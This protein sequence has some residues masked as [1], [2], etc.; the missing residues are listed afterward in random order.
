[1]R[2]L[3]LNLAK[4]ASRFGSASKDTANNVM[5]SIGSIFEINNYLFNVEI[6]EIWNKLLKN[7]WQKE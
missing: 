7:K 1:M 3:K 2:Y 6:D 5:A 4:Y